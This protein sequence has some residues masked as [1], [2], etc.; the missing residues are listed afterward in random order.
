MCLI[1]KVI[2]KK[3]VVHMRLWKTMVFLITLFCSCCIC[4]AQTPNTPES[5]IELSEL[6]LGGVTLNMPYQKVAQ[7]YGEPKWQYGDPNNGIAE[8]GDT[9][10]IGFDKNLVTYV[11][12]LADNGW[13]TPKGIG[14]GMTIDDVYRAYGYLDFS[15]KGT[16]GVYYVYKNYSGKTL[17]EVMAPKKLYVSTDTSPKITSLEIYSSS[18]NGTMP[19]YPEHYK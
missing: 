1:H 2:F 16:K 18:P 17:L 3:G 7:I 11:L 5:D 8:Y 14:V 19:G 4:F 13:R 12:V 9:V 6:S 15:E 10:R